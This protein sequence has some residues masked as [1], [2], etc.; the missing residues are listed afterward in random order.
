MYIQE[1]T[2]DIKTDNDIDI[3]VEEFESLL[4]SFRKSGQSQSNKEAFYITNNS[5]KCNIAT[6][7]KNSIDKKFN[8]VWVTKQ[9]EKLENLCSSKLQVKVLGTSHENYTGSCKCKDHNFLILYTHMFNNAGALDCGNCFKPIPLYRVKKLTQEIRQSILSWEQN[10]ISC[11]NLQISCTVGEKWGTKQM[12]NHK[13]QL[14]KQ[15]IEICSEIKKLTGIP[16]Y[17]YLFNY[18]KISIKKDKKKP[19]PSCK[20]KWLLE[21]K[22]HTLYDFKC[23]KCELISSI[24]SNGF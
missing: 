9:L 3:L 2:I 20:G 24:T 8:T 16:T 6:L 13:S 18:R 7:E 15:G 19:C 10:Y 12:T 22:L 1:L 11:D 14:S 5:I 4:G 21:K 17:Y 23:D